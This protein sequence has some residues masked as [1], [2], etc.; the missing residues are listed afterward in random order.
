MNALEIL[1]VN[2]VHWRGLRK[3]NLRFTRENLEIYRGIT[4]TQTKR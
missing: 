4:Q 2:I 1:N 3:I